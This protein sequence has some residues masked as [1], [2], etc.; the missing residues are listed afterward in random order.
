MLADPPFAAPPVGLASTSTVPEPSPEQAH[1]I[2]SPIKPS[3]PRSWRLCVVVFIVGLAPGIFALWSVLSTPVNPAYAVDPPFF[4]EWIRGRPRSL[5]SVTIPRFYDSVV[6]PGLLI[7]GGGVLLIGG[8]GSVLAWRVVF[9]RR[10]ARWGVLLG[11][12]GVVIGTVLVTAA[13][14]IVRGRDDDARE[15]LAEADSGD[16]YETTVGSCWFMFSGPEIDGHIRVD[17]MQRL[18]DGRFIVRCP[19]SNLTSSERDDLGLPSGYPYWTTGFFLVSPSAVTA[20][21][22]LETPSANIH[23][24]EI[25]DD[26][27]VTAWIT[28]VTGPQH[29]EEATCVRQLVAGV[30][31]DPCE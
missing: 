1:D 15:A 3:G 9:R 31:S 21:G 8:S 11:V 24:F 18:D 4:A 6:R 23:E 28:Y 16:L 19:Y 14:I 12:L 2:A 10:V 26:M 5:G 17:A 25:S 27:V 20:L 30:L 13:P 29:L 22:A 7:F